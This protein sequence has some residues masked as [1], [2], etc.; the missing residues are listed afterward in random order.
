MFYEAV[1]HQVRL[2]P[3]HRGTVIREALGGSYEGYKPHDRRDFI[4][5]MS[6]PRYVVGRCFSRIGA[7]L[8]RRV[9]YCRGSRDSDMVR[10]FI[11]GW[12]NERVARRLKRLGRH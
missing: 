5:H 4:C 12:N 2:T 7:R 8:A 9:Q 1:A 6:K 11:G 10:W 3:W